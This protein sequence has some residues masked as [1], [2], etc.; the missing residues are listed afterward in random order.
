MVHSLCDGQR[1][2]EGVYNGVAKTYDLR[3]KKVAVVMAGNPYNETG[4]KFQIPDMLANRADTYN[5]GE[6]IGE[7]D[8]AFAASFVENSLTSNP[9]LSKLSSQS[10]SDLYALMQA[11]LDGT[12]DG[13][14]LEGNYT[15]AEIQEYTTTLAHLFNVRD[16]I[17]NV[18]KEY[19]RS[20]AQEDAYR[21]EPAF[22]LQ[23]SYRNMNRLS[24]KVLPLM[25]EQEVTGLIHD[26]YQNESQTLTTGAEAN[27]LK[28]HEME[29]SLTGEQTTRWDTIKSDFAKQKLLGGGDNDPVTRVVAQLTSINDTIEKSATSYAQ[30]QTLNDQTIQQLETIIA[31]LR[32]VPVEVEIKVVPVE[33]DGE[34]PRQ[35]PEGKKPPIGVESKTKQGK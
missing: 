33:A 30:P 8:S 16:S 21:T 35:L 34:T 6:I 11:A 2:I 5:L 27:L 23:G 20:A 4:G 31:N 28:F 17:M 22:K 32:A 26:H 29:G 15:P 9:V 1:K 18:N 19:V 12:T 24:E 13:I 3:G 14:D 10:Q 25:T 7:N